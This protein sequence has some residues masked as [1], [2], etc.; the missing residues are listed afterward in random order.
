MSPRTRGPEVFP[1]VREAR[2]ED[3]GEERD[4]AVEP[5]GGLAPSPDRPARGDGP[6]APRRP[7]AT[8]REDAE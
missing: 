2:V 4:D 8:G 6:S 7:D 3:P 5:S 1:G